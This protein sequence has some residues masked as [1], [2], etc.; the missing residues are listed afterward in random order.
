MLGRATRQLT[1]CAL[2]PLHS[3]HV[4]IIINFS[5][6]AFPGVGTITF[7]PFGFAKPLLT[8]SSFITKSHAARLRKRLG[9]PIQAETATTLI[10]TT[11]ATSRTNDILRA[12][13]WPNSESNR[14]RDAS[15]YRT[16]EATASTKHKTHNANFSSLRLKGG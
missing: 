13:R 11:T 5:F 7:G 9:E 8:A 10:A 3:L 2:R 6:F 16:E 1:I 4:Y 15:K 14:V 12:M